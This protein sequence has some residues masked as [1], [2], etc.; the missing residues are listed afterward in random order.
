[1][2]IVNLYVKLG[3]DKRSIQKIVERF[4]S[5][6]PQGKG[7]RLYFI[8]G[9]I[10]FS[11]DKE[12]ITDEE[13]N[14]PEEF[15]EICAYLTDE[16]ENIIKRA[17]DEF[18]LV[19]S[20]PNDRL[21]CKMMPSWQSVINQ[22]HL[23]VWRKPLP[24]SGG[25]YEYKVFGRYRDIPPQAFFHAQ[26]DLGYRKTW[27]KLVI[28]LEVVDQDDKTSCEVVQWVM[29]FPYPMYGREYVYIRKQLIDEDNQMMVLMSHSID[30]PSCPITSEYV[31]V[32]TYLSQMVIKSHTKF[33]ENGF[34]YILTYYDNPKGHFPSIAYN[35][36]ASTGVP[37]FVDK[38]HQSAKQLHEQKKKK[39]PVTGRQTA[40]DDDRQDNKGSDKVPIQDNLFRLLDPTTTHQDM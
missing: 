40:D 30:H 19:Q 5:R 7:R 12:K 1:M 25:L 6:W 32:D 17:M 27:D 22:D 21:E 23:K 31:R 24:H 26:V 39:K 38:M 8:F 29:H 20:N 36:M 35:W 16:S 9:A 10:G 33:D 15:P 34:D 18:H 37:D 13:I 28:K 4:S 3:Y 14:R 2:Q 11:W